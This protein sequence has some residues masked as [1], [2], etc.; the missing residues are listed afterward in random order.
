MTIICLVRGCQWY[1]AGQLSEGELQ[2]E[3][4]VRCGTMR[5]RHMG[6]GSLV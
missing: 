2:S 3:R 5:Y 1:S 6:N 4:C